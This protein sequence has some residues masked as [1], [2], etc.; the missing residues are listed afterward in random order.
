[1]GAVFGRNRPAT[2]FAFDLKALTAA[3]GHQSGT[4]NWISAPESNDPK[5]VARIRELRAVGRTVVLAL[6]GQSD[7][8][9]RE[10]LVD[11]DGDWICQPL[12]PG[13]GE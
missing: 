8:R 9:C 4:E 11:V 1:V 6:N 7:A 10:Q 3:S 13:E 12:G 5:L 2:G